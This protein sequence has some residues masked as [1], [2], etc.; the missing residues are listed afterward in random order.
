MKKSVI[1]LSVCVTLSALALPVHAEDY[2]WKE[3]NGKLYWYENGVRQGVKGDPKNLTD[4]I[5]G[6]ERGREIYD[7]ESDAWYWLD[8]N[9]DGAKA[10]S[11]DVWLPYVYQ[12]ENPGSTMGKWVR[13]DE[14]G[15]MVK[16]VQFY[17]A[18]R[19]WYQFDVVTGAMLKGLRHTPAGNVV[20]Y[21]EITGVLYENDFVKDGI[22]YA[23]DYD[24]AHIIGC[25]HLDL[26]EYSDNQG[27]EPFLIFANMY[28][29]EY[30]SGYEVKE[31]SEVLGTELR[32][33]FRKLDIMQKSRLEMAEAEEQLKIGRPVTLLTNTD[34]F[35]SDR[36]THRRILLLFGYREEGNETYVLFPDMKERNGWY[37]L[38]EL[39]SLVSESPMD[40]RDGLPVTSYWI[41]EKNG[42]R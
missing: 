13:Y 24:T 6:I 39:Y 20:Y 14:Q 37:S 38:A 1:C 8:A 40:I 25:E 34:R 11:K 27:T 2:G 21:D 23:V 5:F 42:S 35:D 4:E 33:T 15:H 22:Q 19:S 26:P 16:G 28:L 30:L 29:I 18:N 36:Q 12:G 9:A 17:E 7:P 3:E 41:E 32:E 31:E 10:V